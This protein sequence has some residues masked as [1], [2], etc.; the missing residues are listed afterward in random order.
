MSRLII[1][2]GTDCSGKE[3]Q[4]NMLVDRLI[5]EGFRVSKESFPDYSTPIGKIIGGPYLG[6]AEICE[7]FFPEGPANVDP[8]VAGHLY[9]A[10]RLELR[11]KILSKLDNGEIVVLD[12]YTTSNMAHQGGKINSYEDRLD[13]YQWCINM[14]YV[15]D[16]MPK[17]DYTIFLHMPYEAACELK[18]NRTDIDGHEKDPNHL[19]NAENSYVELA[20]MFNWDEVYCINQE[21]YENVS[22]IK[23]PIEINEDVY[24]KVKTK[25]LEWNKKGVIK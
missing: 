3:T 6:K 11:S 13:Y 12:R 24:Y 1:V 4:T 8:K 15:N 23:T 14:E 18:K 10:N 16:K 25:I 9:A 22:N 7:S 19:K 2:E 5:K 17:P 20:N 21:K